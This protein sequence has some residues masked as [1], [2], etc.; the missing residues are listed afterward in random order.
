[1]AK[2][3][4]K[5]YIQ[6]SGWGTKGE[7]QFQEVEGTPVQIKGAEGA[8]L[9]L[10]RPPAGGGWKIS[11]GINGMYVAWGNTKK[12]AIEDASQKGKPEAI[13][14]LLKEYMA[15]G[16]PLSPRFKLSGRSKPN[17]TSLPAG[18][19]VKK[20]KNGWEVIHT[21]SGNRLMPFAYPERQLATDFAIRAGQVADWTRPFKDL[22]AESEKLADLIRGGKKPG[23]FEKVLDMPTTF[24]DAK[25][26]PLRDMT[27]A[28]LKRLRV[29][30]HVL[31]DG[32]LEI[33]E[34][35]ADSLERQVASWNPP[36]RPDMTE[37]SRV[38]GY[39]SGEKVADNAKSWLSAVAKKY[40]LD[41]NEI[42]SDS[43][44]GG[45]MRHK[46]SPYEYTINTFTGKIKTIGKAKDKA[47]LPWEMTIKQYEKDM[48][49]YWAG[50]R[51]TGPGSK[52]LPED[53]SMRFKDYHKELVVHAL[54]EGKPV[55]AAVLADYPDLKKQAETEARAQFTKKWAKSYGSRPETVDSF[56]EAGKAMGLTAKQIQQARDEGVTTIVGLRRI[57]KN[58]R[59]ASKATD[60]QASHDARSQ[61]SKPVVKHD[62][63]TGE[64]EVYNPDIK[65]YG[66]VLASFR[67][68]R[69]ADAF[70]E[71][72]LL[73]QGRTERSKSA[74][75]SRSNAL[76][77]DPDDPRVEQ[78]I[79]D[80]GRMDVRG[81][82][83]PSRKPRKT[84]AS[85]IRKKTYRGKVP[86]QSRG[87]N[88]TLTQVRGLR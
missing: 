67:T 18:L 62:R 54:S 69:E 51:G 80:Q 2:Q 37:H 38:G 56:A 45:G 29:I 86:T 74:D 49:D 81:I 6:V 32:T 70:S 82:D 59:R 88:S 19:S 22:Q 28:E 8:D 12:R 65:H 41:L 7:S 3:K 71:L 44:R 58:T 72:W 76:A 66:D 42:I 46:A 43:W 78:W 36:N 64:W 34:K 20:A 5:Y 79:K 68:E 1:M 85:A 30:L 61:Y 52:S 33:K 55:P 21:A 75:E 77:I 24:P 23:M 60:P 39:I 35:S 47:K 16:K 26:K 48:R 83:T 63:G 11:S 31:P 73:E 53:M 50:T 84:R 27:K 15:S 14:R 13:M 87:H 4:D 10:H 40:D 9:F 57:E 25:R 17:P